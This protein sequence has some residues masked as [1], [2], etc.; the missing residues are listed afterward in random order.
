MHITMKKSQNITT[1]NP[2]YIYYIKSYA[3]VT[4][5]KYT[6]DDVMVQK[7][8]QFEIGEKSILS[9]INRRNKIT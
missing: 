1:V 5:S 7:G 9:H 2:T 8:R 3:H 4:D 6:T